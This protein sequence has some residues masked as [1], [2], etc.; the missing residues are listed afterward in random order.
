MEYWNNGILGRDPG[1]TYFR[2]GLLFKGI[3][4]IF[5]SFQY[6]SRDGVPDLPR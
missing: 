2:F 6:S 5:P 4:S 1:A 3:Y